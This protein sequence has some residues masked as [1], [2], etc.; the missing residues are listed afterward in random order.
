MACDK[1]L[2]SVYIDGEMPDEF[3]SEFESHLSSCQNCSALYKKLLS[4]K[5]LFSANKISFAT[6]SVYLDQSFQRLQTRLSYSKNTGRH[7]NK[8]VITGVRW[9]SSI[10]AA[11]AVLIFAVIPVS[12]NLL[13]SGN[14]EPVSSEV[15]AVTR[16]KFTPPAKNE[17]KADGN[18][19]TTASGTFVAST[20]NP[21]GTSPAA[22]QENPNQKVI[23]AVIASYGNTFSEMS[24]IDIFRPEFSEYNFSV[25][26][27]LRL[28]Q[29]KFNQQ[30]MQFPMN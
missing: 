11:A 15:V 17:I 16:K 24:S 18:L 6:D 2:V 4:Q 30:P 19:A 21:D 9:V 5:A 13:S 3:K 26:F 1:D 20:D 27:P 29:E 25:E 23:S 14:G 28:H 8:N 7:E 10:A 22:P 12:K